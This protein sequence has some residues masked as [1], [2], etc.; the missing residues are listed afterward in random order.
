MLRRNISIRE[1]IAELTL[2]TV[3]QHLRIAWSRMAREPDR[4]VSLLSTDGDIWYFKK[5][6]RGGRTASRMTQ[7]IGWL[8]QLAL[9]NEKGCTAKGRQYLNR[10]NSILEMETR[11]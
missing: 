6:F 11:I 7:T 3:D 10:I 9:L 5:A 8:N 1:A 2:R 4:D